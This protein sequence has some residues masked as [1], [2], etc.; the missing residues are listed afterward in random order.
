VKNTHSAE[1]DGVPRET[2]LAAG[3]EF[4]IEVPLWEA[5]TS[6]VIHGCENNASKVV[7]CSVPLRRVMRRDDDE[8][9]KLPH[10]R[11]HI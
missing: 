2:K 10:G 1:S 11:G 9:D 7:E 4:E 5:L 6:A 3:K 8:I